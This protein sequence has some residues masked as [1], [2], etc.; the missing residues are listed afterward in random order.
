MYKKYKDDGFE[1]LGIAQE[2]GLTLEDD[3]KSWKDAIAMDELPWLQVLNNE[4]IEQF[5]AVKTYGVTSFPTKILL[6]KE[7]N[8]IGRYNDENSVLD[9]KLKEIFDK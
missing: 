2:T 5:D 8:I 1:I 3:R 4:G 6:D 7:G 9:K